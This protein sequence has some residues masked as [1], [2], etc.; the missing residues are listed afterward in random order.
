MRRL[1]ESQYRQVIADVF[2]DDIVVGGRFDP[3]NRV[4]GLLACGSDLLDVPLSQFVGAKNRRILQ[5]VLDDR[6]EVTCR[7]IFGNL[8]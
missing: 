2:G 7:V 6:H 3:V 1:T 8:S 4:D 5:V